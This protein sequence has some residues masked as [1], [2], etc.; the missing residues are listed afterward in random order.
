MQ[1]PKLLK[2]EKL[3]K[4]KKRNNQISQT[5]RNAPFLKLKNI[6]LHKRVVDI[7]QF[8]AFSQ[9]CLFLFE[10]EPVLLIPKSQK[11]INAF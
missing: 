10:K 1:K 8:L 4:K 3:R 2:R 11:H 6:I 7:S 9:I 5:E